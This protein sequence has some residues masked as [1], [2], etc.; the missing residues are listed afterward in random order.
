VE[1]SAQRLAVMFVIYGL[2]PAGPELRILEFARSFSD[3]LDV[4]VCVVGDDLT[5]LDEF[6]KTRARVIHVP[7][8]R[9]YVEWRQMRTVF[10][11]IGRHDIRVL[12]SFNLKTLL[13][14]AGAKMRYG[15]RVRVVHHLISLWEDVPSHVRPVI[16]STLRCADRILCNGYAV[17]ERLIGSRRLSAPVTVIPNGVDCDRFRPS[18]ELRAAE[19]ARLGCADDDFVLG[20]VGNVRP[21][22]N[23]PFLLNAMTRIAG[24]HPNARLL[25]VG[26]GPQLEEMKALAGS[27]GLGERVVFTGLARDVRPYLAAMD[28]F[29]LCSRQEGNP[30]VVLQAMAMAVPVVSVRVG[31]VPAVI[32][33]GTSG[34]LVDPGDDAAFVAAVS[35]LAADACLRRTLGDQA[36]RRVTEVYSSSQMMAGYAALMQQAAA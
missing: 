22:K 31:E 20:T 34:L 29:A 25:C 27:L 3:D 1:V 24:I 10:D 33:H 18:P 16:W 6:Q 30:N 36:R 2:E 28:T 9:P 4:H 7:M 5:M 15:S 14:C 21:V 19:R 11:Y 8:R 17:K 13:V 23:Y 32:E 12:N 35:K 26:G